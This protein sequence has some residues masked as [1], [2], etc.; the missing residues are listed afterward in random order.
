MIQ[1]PVAVAFLDNRDVIVAEEYCVQGLGLTARVQRF[2]HTGQ[3]V[4]LIN[5]GRLKP[6]GFA[7]SRGGLLAVADK[8]L[9]TVCFFHEDGRYAS[10][11]WPKRMFGMPT[12]TDILL[13]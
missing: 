13:C 12:G 6:S 4:A 10:P 7:V 11:C 8:A 1:Y 2:D 5:F 9:R 3:S